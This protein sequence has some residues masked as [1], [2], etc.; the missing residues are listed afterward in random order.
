VDAPTWLAGYQQG[1]RKFGNDEAQAVAH[2]DAI[3][4][5]SQ[6]SG[7]FSDRSA[8]ERG[9]VSRTARQNDVVRL[10]T[11]LGSYM[12]AKFNVAYERSVKAS[13]VV[14]E[15][16]MSAKSAAEVLSWT[17]DMAFLFAVEAVVLAAIKGKLPDSDEDEDDTWLK[18]LAKETAMGVM[19]TV[20]FVRDVGSTMGGFEGGGAYG[21]MTKE[22]AQPVKEI[23]QG[24]FDK[25]LVKSI[26]NATGLATGLPA[27]QINR[28]VD[29][30]WRRREGDDVSPLEYLLGKAGKSK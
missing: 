14:R 26:I 10:F 11:T 6:A 16:G 8:V 4:K 13:R 2:A 20:P 12:F 1:L 19:S 25:G 27:T 21:A 28:A 3:L 18:F 17:V 30:E 9:S 15:E 23:V 24:E 22:L 29:A 7:L 5:R